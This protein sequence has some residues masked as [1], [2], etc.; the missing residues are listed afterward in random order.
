MRIAAPPTP[1]GP[2]RRDA[3]PRTGAAAARAG[4]AGI[5]A[6]GIDA[7]GIDTART[8][9]ADTDVARAGG[10][11]A[12][13]AWADGTGAEPGD[14]PATREVTPGRG[15]R[16][17]LVLLGVTSAVLAAGAVAYVVV[18]APVPSRTAL[19]PTQPEA[20]AVTPPAYSGLGGS[21]PSGA[22]A[23]VSADASSPAA[24]STS[25]TATATSSAPVRQGAPE[26]GESRDPD[27]RVPTRPTRTAVPTGEPVQPPPVDEAPPPV[28]DLRAAFSRTA[29]VLPLGLGG[30][31]G[32]VRLDNPGR[33][34][35]V[36]WRVRLTVPGGNPVVPGEG[37]AVVQNGEQVVFRPR[38][39]LARVPAGDS[40]SFTF[41]VGG[42]LA[43]EP[44][45]CFIDGDPCS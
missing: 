25:P 3:V 41:T 34:A 24:G 19:P 7:A 31:V 21:K 10:A 36:G 37:V 15:R 26:A 35:A 29:D 40:V 32:T 30:Y 43:A 20:P 39:G 4:T 9:A 6:A 1:A 38:A 27:S 8:D 45:G 44:S 2:Q 42:V 5:D 18:Q 14:D 23:S 13:G 11:R 12:G 16:A 22:A 33:T 17:R 28:A